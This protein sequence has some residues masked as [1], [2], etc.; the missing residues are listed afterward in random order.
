[1]KLSHASSSAAL[2][3]NWIQDQLQNCKHFFQYFTLLTACIST[4][5][6]V[7]SHCCSFPKVLQYRS[8]HH[9]VHMHSIMRSQ[10]LLH[11]LKFELSAS[12]SALLQLSRDFPPPPQDSLL[13]TSLVIL[14]RYLPPTTS[15]SSLAYACLKFHLL[16]TYWLT[17]PIAETM[18]TLH[19]IHKNYA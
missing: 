18:S 15:N 7:L 16:T 1:M 6:H 4:L 5:P 17:V 9:S 2:A 8:V 19:Y 3:S 14:P 13:P 12:S 10:L 11:L